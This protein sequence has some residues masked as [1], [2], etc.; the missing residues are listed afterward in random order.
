MISRDAPSG[1][2]CRK[3]CALIQ[4]K[5]TTTKKKKRTEVLGEGPAGR[6]ADDADG[7][8]RLLPAPRR[9]PE[10]DP[11]Q[12]RSDRGGEGRFGALLLEQ[13]RGSPGVLA[14]GGEDTR[15]DAEF[16]GFFF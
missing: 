13:R 11:D 7:P 15:V 14:E 16:D 1:K 3:S 9:F 6:R 12:P 2:T 5:K 4:I 8:G 10:R